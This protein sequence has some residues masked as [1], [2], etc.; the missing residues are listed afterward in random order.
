MEELLQRVLF[1]RAMGDDRMES[2]D[3][4][5]AVHFFT[6][7]ISHIAHNP[8]FVYQQWK[9]LVAELYRKRCWAHQVTNHYLEASQDFLK[10]IELD[11]DCPG[12]NI[13]SLKFY[14]FLNFIVYG[15]YYCITFA[16][17]LPRVEC[18]SWSVCTFF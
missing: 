6:V 7:A 11:K 4:F 8:P 12:L 5:G 9:E 18:S 13:V 15:T 3:F 14:M 1:L 16:K 2:C 10:A 17:W